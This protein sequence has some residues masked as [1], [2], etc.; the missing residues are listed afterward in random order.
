MD[1]IEFEA[2]YDSDNTWISVLV[3]PFG[4]SII[5]SINKPE[6]LVHVR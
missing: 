5:S 6:Y 2:Q 3:C 1:F 4:I